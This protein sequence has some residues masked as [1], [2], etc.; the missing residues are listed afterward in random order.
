MRYEFQSLKC[1]V[2]YFNFMMRINS[3][4]GEQNQRLWQTLTKLTEANERHH[5][6]LNSDGTLCDI[7]CQMLFQAVW[8]FPLS[9]TLSAGI[10][11]RCVIRL[12]VCGGASKH[13][14]KWC[15]LAL[16]LNKTVKYR[17]FSKLIL[18]LEYRYGTLIVHCL[19]FRFFSALCSGN[20]FLLVEYLAWCIWVIYIYIHIYADVQCL[21]VLVLQCTVFWWRTAA[22]GV[23]GPIRVPQS[24]GCGTAPAGGGLPVPGGPVPVLLRQ[25]HGR[26]VRQHGQRLPEPWV[27][28]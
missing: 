11:M 5:A 2:L 6:L 12:A 9:G 7:S 13:K 22:A 10:R 3:R 16:V 28:Q 24:D 26:P 23:P 14:T 27:H 25:H 1:V 17:S 8:V 20:D 18:A 19:F 21:F 4:I 15:L